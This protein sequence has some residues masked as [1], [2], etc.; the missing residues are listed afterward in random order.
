MAKNFPKCK[1][2]TK[3]PQIKQ[4]RKHQAGEKLPFP[5]TPT[6]IKVA[7]NQKQRKRVKPKVAAGCWRGL[8]T[9]TWIRITV[10]AL[11]KSGGM[12]PEH[13]Y[14]WLTLV[15]VWQKSSQYCKITILQ[16]K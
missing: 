12:G 11:G 6:C 5:H 9:E 4:L 7:G 13:V 2:N 3:L 1:I 8:Y 16:L 10:V 15:D 14:L